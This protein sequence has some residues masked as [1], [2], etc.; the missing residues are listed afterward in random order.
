MN[1]VKQYH[2]VRLANYGSKD[3]MSC[4]GTLIMKPGVMKLTGTRYLGDPD[5]TANAFSEDG[6]FKTGDIGHID[7]YK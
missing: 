5:A 6:W 1:K 3:P 2:S 4:K 7:N